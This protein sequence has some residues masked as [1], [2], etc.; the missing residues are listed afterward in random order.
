MKRL[1]P[2][3]LAALLGCSPSSAPEGLLATPFGS[4]ATVNF[5]VTHHPLPEIPLPN[6]FATRFDP[7]S[8]TLLRVNASLIAPTAWESGMRQIIDNLDGWGTFAPLSVSFSAPLDVNNLIRR[9]IG[10]DY[11]FTDDAVYLIDISPDSPDFC[12]PV[13]LDMGEGN[14][15]L[16]LENQDF[17]L[18]TDTR[19]HNQQLIFD[20]VNE[21]VNG[22]GKL[23][24][25]EDTDMDGVLD[26]GNFAHDTDGPF[27][28]MP[29][30]ERESNTLIM[31]PVMPMRENTVYAAVLTR[32]L[33]DESGAPIRS[34]FDYI[35]HAQQTKALTP[36]TQC[37]PALGLGLDDIAFT[38]SFTTQSITRDF[39]A[40]RDGLYGLGN[41]SRL[42]TEYP[43]VISNLFKLRRNLP[44]GQ[45]SYI[46][47]D[48]DIQVLTQSV[49]AAFEGNKI[50]PQ[51]QAVI[52]SYKYVDYVV[53]GQYVSPQFF[54]RT[55]AADGQY[56]LDPSALPG[57]ANAGSGILAR[58]ASG[59]LIDPPLPLYQQV[60]QLDLVT[61]AAYDR[62]E[63]ITFWMTVPKNRGGKPAP[64]VILGHGYTS[65][66][67]E[68]VGYAGYFARM[69]FATIAI[70]CVSHGLDIDASE[71]ALARSE[72]QQLG[73]DPLFDA[74]VLNDRAVDLNGD[75]RKDPGS[76]FW[77]SY[78]LHTRDVVKQSAIDY[79]QLIRLLKTFDGKTRWAYDVKRT[80]TPDLAGDF[81]GDGV[82]DVGGAASIH[83]TGGSLGGIMSAMMG[84]LEPQMSTILPVS[85]GAGLADIGV[86]S[87][88]GGVKEAVNWRM[89]GPMLA[90]QRDPTTMKLQL[91]E[92]VPNLNGSIKL[93]VADFP[94]E[95]NDGDTAIVRNATTGEFR[96]TVVHSDPQLGTALIGAAVSSDVGDPLSLEIYDGPLPSAL[97]QGCAVPDGTT[98]KMVFNTLGYDVTYQAQKF[99]KGTPLIAFTDGFGLRRSSPELRRFMGIAQLAM[100]S[101]DPVNVAPFYERWLLKYGTGEE[102]HTRGMIINT[103]GDMNVPMATGVEIARA[104]GYIELFQKDPRYGKTDNRVLIDTHALEAVER[105]GPYTNSLGQ[106]VLMD[107]DYY[108]NVQMNNDGFDVPRLDPP[109]RLQAQS[110]V[111]GGWRGMMLPMVLPTGKHGFSG[112]D[113]SLPWNLGGF[114]FVT[115]GRYMSTD[116]KSFDLQACNIDFSCDYFPSWAN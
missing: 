39:K 31:K 41:M 26:Q 73:E 71:I 48:A 91:A 55:A 49:L 32:R 19:F 85:G 114:M 51:T 72:A 63:T 54:R 96:C 89:F 75:G 77:T 33:V 112:P 95:P 29:F 47:P 30:Y 111:L 107:V 59:N 43:A 45:S 52:D 3:A 74:V 65:S 36:L 116:G 103:I 37:L 2:L 104:A 109:L 88:Q 16:V 66:K 82:V 84:G 28:A 92:W 21:D 76:D 101:G 100:E 27:T 35:N 78:V 46:V 44:V 10:D 68:M 53:V 7:G 17:G 11:D 110:D 115:M 38:W 40:V 64:V 94:S 56:H 102:V 106:P 80:G 87:I 50:T 8:P 15:P 24:L 25:G 42:S 60:F 22:N 62:P 18:T 12:K 9:H 20:E 61:G 4:G 99:P 108:S 105:A 57:G 58:D 6:D 70:D 90:T 97:P 83:M 93:P 86:R 1:A 69:G 79:M 14:F 13:P 67:V 81:D 5:D 98:P 23:D 113:P 34:P